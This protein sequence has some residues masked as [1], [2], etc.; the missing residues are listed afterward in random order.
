VPLVK[1]PM[2][3]AE[4]DPHNLRGKPWHEVETLSLA[5][6]APFDARGAA[7]AELT[8]R[9]REY[10]EAQ[11]QSRREFERLQMDR[12]AAVADKQ[13]AAAVDV[14]KAT[15]WAVWAAAAAATGAIVQGAVAVI[16]LLGK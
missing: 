4:D 1:E 10:T 15:K 13:L 6:N 8:R 11:E 7:Q 14:A 16:G 3:D 5:G 12:A 9:D 2:P